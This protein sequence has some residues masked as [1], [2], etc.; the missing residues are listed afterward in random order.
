MRRGFRLIVTLTHQHMQDGEGLLRAVTEIDVV[1]GGRDHDPMTSTVGGRLI[2]KAGSD[3]KWLGVTRVPLSGLPRAVHELVPITDQ[4]PSDP[5]MAGLIKRYTDQL[6]RDLAVAIGETTVP[7]D[8]R[9]QALRQQEAALG[10]YI[11]DMHRTDGDAPV[12]IT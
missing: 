4:T 10:N 7:L 8:A 12:S 9:N 5:E 3:A 6:A 1:I 2:A 11:A